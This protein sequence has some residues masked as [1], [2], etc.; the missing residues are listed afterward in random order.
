VRKFGKRHLEDVE[1]EV[2]TSE[3]VA[4][5]CHV[6]LNSGS[7][8]VSL[9]PFNCFDAEMY[10]DELELEEPVDFREDQ[11]SMDPQIRG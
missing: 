1:L 8:T 5:W 4:P 11:R 10:A 9:N 3:A 6:E 2:N 7:I